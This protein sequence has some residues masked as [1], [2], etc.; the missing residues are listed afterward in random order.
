MQ[1]CLSDREGQWG[2][3]ENGQGGNEG[4]GKER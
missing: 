2:A 4:E 3:H 1:E